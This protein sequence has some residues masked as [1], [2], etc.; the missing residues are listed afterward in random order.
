[1]FKNNLR[2][3]FDNKEMKL[4]TLKSLKMILLKLQLYEWPLKTWMAYIKPF[5]CS[6]K[7]AAAIF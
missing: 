1:M 6:L 4:S 3:M 2:T 5:A 7:Q